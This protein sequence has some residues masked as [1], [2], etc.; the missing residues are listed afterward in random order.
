MDNEFTRSALHFSVLTAVCFEVK[1]TQEVCYY[2][3][4]LILKLRSSYYKHVLSGT[5][6]KHTFVSLDVTNLLF[7]SHAT[8]Y[9]KLNQE[10]CL[11]FFV[12]MLP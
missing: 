4:C 9:H 7:T 5:C 2:I 8:E 6:K 1:V 12:Q 10:S 3:F 11:S